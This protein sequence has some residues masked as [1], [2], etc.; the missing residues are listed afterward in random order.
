MVG[1]HLSREVKLGNKDECSESFSVVLNFYVVICPGAC[2]FSSAEDD[3]FDGGV[4]LPR[5][6]TGAVAATWL[7]A[8]RANTAN[9]LGCQVNM[10]G[11]LSVRDL[12]I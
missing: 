5:A 9:G 3:C 12:E 6:R 1:L 2:T 7:D 10:S 11:C 4:A 8:G